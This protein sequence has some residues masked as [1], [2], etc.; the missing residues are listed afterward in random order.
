MDFLF[1]VHFNLRPSSPFQK[2]GSRDRYCR[3][4][5]LGSLYA[6]T[7]EALGN[8]SSPIKQ[9]PLP[10]V[11]GVSSCGQPKDFPPSAAIFPMPARC[12]A[13]RLCAAAA[14]DLCV[15]AA[16]AS[17]RACGAIPDGARAS[18]CRRRDGQSSRGLLLAARLRDRRPRRARPTFAIRRIRI[19]NNATATA[20]GNATGI[21]RVALGRLR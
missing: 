10:L 16:P 2:V 5:G 7:R 4:L 14:T 12:C 11:A 6:S 19:T 17:R 9:K 13:M 3:I 20:D 18:R 1:G 15:A 21:R 8:L